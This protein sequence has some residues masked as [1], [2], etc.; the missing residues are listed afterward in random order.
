MRAICTVSVSVMTVFCLLV[1]GHLARA[2]G[3]KVPLQSNVCLSGVVDKMKLGNFFL[4][5]YDVGRNFEAALPPSPMPGWQRLFVDQGALLKPQSGSVVDAFHKEY[6]ADIMALA[7]A[8]VAFSQF[9]RNATDTENRDPAKRAYRNVTNTEDPADFLTSDQAKLECLTTTSGTPVEA[10]G[11]EG[12]KF[13]IS[14]PSQLRL[15]GSTD[16]L[17]FGRLE[18]QFKSLD[19]ATISFSY[20]GASNKRIDKLLA[21]LGYS[22]DFGRDQLIPYIGTNR[23]I[24]NVTKKPSTTN[25]ETVD[26]GLLNALSVPI[27]FKT[28]EEPNRPVL[29]NWLTLRPDYLFD[30]KD[31]SRLFSL[32]FVYMPLIN[33]ILNDYIMWHAASV[34][35]RPIVDA[36]LDE[37][38][39]TARGSQ[40]VVRNRDYTRLGTQF[41]L[42]LTSDNGNIPLDA[43]LTYTYLHGFSGF[44]GEVT[45]LK[46]SVTLSFTKERYL[47]ITLSTS[48]GRRE[49]TAQHEQLWSI[50]LG[51]RF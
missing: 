51:G 30:L 11:A 29:N 39:Y 48:Y 47:G 36:R 31:D 20:D 50:S 21:V 34:S 43:T 24:V 12:K 46:S 3:P 23:N 1:T 41:G 4:S 44:F 17:Y 49:D 37:G 5:A 13:A 6:Q 19:A 10:A 15:R 35:L 26:V 9:L 28:D 40:N 42:A 7:V 8:R 32:Q 14:I 33:G 38:I 2:A 25:T 18:P 16:G 22:L 27:D 45:S